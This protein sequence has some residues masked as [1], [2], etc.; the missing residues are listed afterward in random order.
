MD[1][2]ARIAIVS[3]T[4]AAAFSGALAPATGDQ[5]AARGPA[6]NVSHTEDGVPYVRS[7][8]ECKAGKSAKQAHS[9]PDA[10]DY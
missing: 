4:A 10:S 8:P 1:R 3:V 5:R 2:R 7:G 6:A 9:R